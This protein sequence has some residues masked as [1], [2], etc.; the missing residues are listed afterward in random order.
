LSE[1]LQLRIAVANNKNEI[2]KTENVELCNEVRG[3]DVLLMNK[4][5]GLFSIHSFPKSALKK[6]P[7]HRNIYTRKGRRKLPLSVCYPPHIILDESRRFAVYSND[8][9]IVPPRQIGISAKSKSKEIFLK[10]L[11]IYLKSNVAYYLQFWRAVNIGIERDVFNLDS[12]KKL[13][14]PLYFLTEGE[15]AEWA[16]LHDEIVE[17]ERKEKRAKV[18]NDKR[19]LWDERREGLSHFDGSLQKLNDLLEQMNNKVYKLFEISKK[20]QWVIEDMLDVRMKLNDGVFDAIEAINPATEKEMNDFAQIFQEELDLFL[21]HSGKRKV[22]KVNVYYA[23]N[24]AFMIIDHLERPTTTKPGANKIEDNRI[25]QEINHLPG[26]LTETRSQWIYFTRCLQ[27][28]EGRRT[29]IF[30]PRQRLYWLKSQALAEADDFIAEK[31]ETN[32]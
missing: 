7:E 32:K 31:L 29:Y 23:D 8:F 26:N 13:P 17:T 10:A 12:L 19:T 6:Q 25:R 21:D 28:Y 4:L 5:E 16:E 2:E 22:H 20:Q 11:A 24:S 3:K 14:I 30:K 1:G 27:I 18:K 15:L 9:V